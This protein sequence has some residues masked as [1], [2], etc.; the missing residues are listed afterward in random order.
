[1]DN[2]KQKVL[3][4]LIHIKAN[5]PKDVTLGIC[6][7]VGVLLGDN[8]D[9]YEA[10]DALLTHVFESWPNKSSSSAYPVGKWSLQPAKLFWMYF[11]NN[12]SMWDK[13]TKYGAARYEL[14][15][16]CINTLS[17]QV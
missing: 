3:A 5:G 14:L 1:M 11:D 6:A 13:G 12:K 8:A 4:A 9:M 2:L 15:D 7:E 16:H 17:L 10:L